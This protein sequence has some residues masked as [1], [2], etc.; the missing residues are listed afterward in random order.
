MRAGLEFLESRAWL[1][2]ELGQL[3]NASSSLPVLF[4]GRE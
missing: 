3:G 1:D 2:A 4:L